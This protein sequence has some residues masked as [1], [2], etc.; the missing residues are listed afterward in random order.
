[1]FRSVS[2]AAIAVGSTIISLIV[3]IL[4]IFNFFSG[5]VGGIWLAIK[6]EW[7]SIGLGFLLGFVKG[8]GVRLA[9]FGNFR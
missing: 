5:I 8:L 3:S 4:I 2:S 6:G 7:G 1:M 9:I